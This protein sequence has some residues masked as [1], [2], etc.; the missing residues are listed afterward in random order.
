MS[1]H[2]FA[3]YPVPARRVWPAS[4][5]LPSNVDSAL[6][7]SAMDR[8][9]SASQGLQ[10]LFA[11]VPSIRA[12]L[13]DLLERELDLGEPDAGFLFQA[14]D[15]LPWQF[16]GFTSLLAFIYHKEQPQIALDRPCSVAGLGSNHPMAAL[17]PIQCLLRIKALDPEKELNRRWNT[18]WNARAPGTAF[19]RRE[20]AGRLYQSHLEATAQV[21][22]A[23][24][25]LTTD[26]LQPLWLLMDAS[27]PEPRLDDQPVYSER[28]E[29]V[30]GNDWPGQIPGTWVISVGDRQFGRQLLYLPHHPV[31]FQS[32]ARRSD[33]EAWL[34]GQGF[35]PEGLPASGLRFEY[36]TGTQSLT[37]DVTDVLAR[38]QQVRINTLRQGSAGKNGLAEHGAR[39]LEQADR[40][41]RQLRIIG[42]TAAPPALPPS[43]PA[44]QDQEQPLFG[45][46]TADIPWSVRQAALERQRDALQIWSTVATDED[47]QT[48]EDQLQRLEAAELAADSAAQSMLYRERVLDMV[49]LNREFTSLHRAHKNGLIAEAGLQHTLKQ[50]SEELYQALLSVL[51]TSGDG[52]VDWC[53]A[54]ISLSSREPSDACRQTLNGPLV[55]TPVAALSDPAAPHALLLYWPGTGGGLQRFDNRRELERE[56]FKVQEQDPSLTLQLSRIT[57]DPLQHALNQVSGEFEEQAGV[58]RRSYSDA[59]RSTLRAEHLETLRRQFVARLQVPVSAARQLAFSHLAEQAKSAALASSLPDWLIN[60]PEVDRGGLRSLIEA[61]IK[62]MQRSQALMERALPPRDEFTRQH[63]HARLRKD[64][65]LKGLFEVQVEL[66]DSVAMQQHTYNAPGAP[67]TPT[68][69]VMIPSPARSKTPLE[70]L[71]QTNIDNTPSMSM[72]PLALRLGFMKVDVTASDETERRTLAAGITKAYLTRTLPDLDLPKAYETL[73]HKVFMG[74]NDDTPFVNEHRRECLLE[75]WRLMLRLQGECARLQKQISVQDLQILDIA[76]D[77]DTFPA[78]RANNK[79]IVLLPALLTSGGRDTPNEGPVT[80]SGVSFIQEQVSG[81]T[82]LYLADSPDSQVLRR[83]DNLEAAR[84]AL[85]NLCVQEKWSRYLAGRAVQGDVRAHEHRIEQAVLKRFDTLIGVGERWPATTSLAAHLL[86]AQMGRLIQAHRSTSRANADLADERY[87]LSGSRVFIYIKMALGLVPFVGTAIGLYD[88]WTSANQ[89]VAAFLRG[90]VGDGLAEIEGLLLALVD[91]A[92]DILPTVGAGSGAA[93]LTRSRQLRKLAAGPAVL[94]AP[95]KRTARHMKERFAG[96][97][98][99]QPVFLSGM[100]PASAGLF[101]NVYRHADGDFVFRQ[102]RAYQVELSKDSRGWRLAGNSQKTYKQPIALDEAGNWDTH[103]GVYGTMFDGGGAGGGNVFG[104]LADALDPVWPM[105][106]RQRLPRWWGDRVFRRQHQLTET[107]DDLARQID[108]RFAESHAAITRYNDAPFDQR[109][110]L[111][112]AADAACIGDIEMASRRYRV[113]TDLL[114]L[115]HGNKRRKVIECMS[116]DAWKVADRLQLRVHH[117]NHQISPLLD[118]IDPLIE[119]LIELPADFLGEHISLHRQ[120]RSLRLETMQRTEEL[121]RLMADLNQ[122]YE[123][124][125]LPRDKAQMRAE[126]EGLN[127]RL[128]ESNL[129]YLKTGSLLEMVQNYDKLSEVSWH[130]LHNQAQDLRARIDRALYTQFSLPETSATRAQRNRILQDCLDTYAQFRRAMTVWT[131]SYSQH[132]YMEDVPALLAGIEKMADRARRAFELPTVTAP[133]GRSTKKIFTTE[134]DQLLIGI[135]HWESTTQTRRYHLTGKGGAEEIWEQGSNGKYRLLSSPARPP[136]PVERNL[137]ALLTEARTR[138]DRLPV[139]EIKVNTHARQD[140]L[141]VDLEHMMVSEADELI[142]RAQRIEPIDAQNPLIAILRGKAT[143]LRIRGR[144]MRTRQSLNSKNP[145]DGMLDD[146]IGQNAVDIQKAQPLKNLGKRKDGR[147]DYLQEYKIRDLTQAQPRLLWYAHFHYTKATP[148]FRDFEKAHLKLPEHRSMTHADNPSLPYA[149]IGKRSS[150]L[151]HFENL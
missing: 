143:E 28:L 17:T 23:Q 83:Y 76:I 110:A 10:D 132:F 150:V 55:I 86:N 142:R 14:T 78:W 53:A 60:L 104:H 18:Y 107:T 105:S 36:I 135:E 16:V 70:T 119:R 4:L 69:T 122:W 129:L 71:A 59:A 37:S 106:V 98:Y 43:M 101:R 25:S 148:G 62:A 12:S 89:A 2:I 29:L 22:L 85:F 58:I 9:H 50:L 1:K 42:I 96:Y 103:F 117:V 39:T 91:A 48:F 116:L 65:S 131:A 31:P 82:L 123:R 139:Y 120:I 52:D 11:G 72:E 27:S 149:D 151:I 134:D 121:E 113:L 87:A 73:I 114:P 93:T 6:L 3:D 108:V 51:D 99:Q 140:M 141:P 147:I 100:E 5:P 8:W 146:L 81:T 66:P 111:R 90:A 136:T 144:Q 118:R 137:Q 138:L 130:F 15:T 79:R 92:M 21:A 112:A 75:P 67:G 68:K 45:A 41:E 30:P 20:Q 32:F 145:T 40:L 44:T 84:K 127:K 77:A 63:L 34:S 7:R 125:S 38:L 126:I 13:N 33:L 95:D 54:E 124:I 61:Y 49:T 57:G 26:Q 97:E 46:L 109:P 19:S 80:I 64:F 128:S 94:H 74:S 133:I 88:A 35:A 24:R 115:T 102:G 56:V 47:R